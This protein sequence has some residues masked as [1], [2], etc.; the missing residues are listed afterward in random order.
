MAVFFAE[1]TVAIPGDLDSRGGTE[2]TASV[3]FAVSFVSFDSFLGSSLVETS[4]VF[5]RKLAIV[6]TPELSDIRFCSGIGFLP[7]IWGYFA[8]LFTIGR[9]DFLTFGASFAF[10]P[11]FF[12]SSF[13]SDF[14]SASGIPSMTFCFVFSL[15]SFIG[16]KL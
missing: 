4:S 7:Y 10:L 1:K 8:F 2:L 15:S 11:L 12:V 3:L 6:K 9:P 5:V 16:G 13:V 14:S